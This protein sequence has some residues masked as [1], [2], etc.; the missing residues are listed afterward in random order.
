V[1]GKTGWYPNIQHFKCALQF[2]VRLGA[3]SPHPERAI[4]SIL[5]DHLRRHLARLKLGGHFLE[6]HSESFNLLLLARDGA[7]LFFVL[8]MLFE[9][10]VEQHRVHGIVAHG[11]DLAVVVAKT[12][13]QL[14]VSDFL[15]KPREMDNTRWDRQRRS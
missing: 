9:K 14:A 13:I 7:F 15:P 11:V 6:A 12:T 4:L 10:F 5:Q 1:W 8:A 2:F 3:F